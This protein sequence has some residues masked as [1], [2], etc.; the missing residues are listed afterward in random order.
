MAGARLAIGAV[1]ACALMCAQNKTLPTLVLPVPGAPLSAE[2][3]EEHTTKLA[4]GTSRTEV[5][6]SKV[7]R[8]AAGRLRDEH[9]LDGSEGPEEI[10]TITNQPDGFLVLLVPSEKTGGRLLF[11]KDQKAGVGFS[12]L[13]NPLMQ[14]LGKKSTKTDDLGKQ[15]IEGIEF[16]GRRT[17]ITMDE[18][19]SV[20]GVSEEWQN[21]DLRVFGLLTATGPDGQTSIK[22]RNVDRR[23]P[24]PA[25]F[26]IPSDYSIRDLTDDRPLK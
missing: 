11:P 6:V 14:A 12:L 4:D 8:D 7:Y 26:E 9:K 15:M 2:V 1:L 5:N 25:L 3:V 23:P 22:L 10:V 24:D 16:E 19:P 13:G 18:Q 21:R 20:A 17:T